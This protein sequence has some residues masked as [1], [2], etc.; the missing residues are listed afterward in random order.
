MENNKHIL[1]YKSF[2]SKLQI[3]RDIEV[4]NIKGLKKS[5]N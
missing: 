1:L 4:K 3:L 2:Y 5:I